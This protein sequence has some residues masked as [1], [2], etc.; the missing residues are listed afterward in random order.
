[1]GIGDKMQIVDNRYLEIPIFELDKE[2]PDT[3]PWKWADIHNRPAVWLRKESNKSFVVNFDFISTN[4]RCLTND[5]AV[6]LDTKFRTE[7]DSK[8]VYK[9]TYRFG[10][11][12]VV[13]AYRFKDIE[14]A[15]V[16]HKTLIDFLRNK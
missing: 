3:E 8:N 1:M 13:R 7:V 12:S 10:A 9:V 4:N 5:D 15:R 11:A 2:E 14:A 6:M 16:W